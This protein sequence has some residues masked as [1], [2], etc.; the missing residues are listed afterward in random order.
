MTLRKTCPSWLLLPLEEPTPHCQL[1]FYN[2]KN[3]KGWQGLRRF[4]Q[5]KQEQ[6]KH[7]RIQILE[8]TLSFGQSLD[9]E[10]DLNMFENQCLMAVCFMAVFERQDLRNK[11]RA[12][13][14][15]PLKC[16]FEMMKTSLQAS[17]NRWM[18]WQNSNISVG[19]VCG[20]NLRFHLEERRFAAFQ[21]DPNLINTPFTP[22][23]R[24]RGLWSPT[25]ESR[26]SASVKVASASL[27]GWPRI[28]AGM[29]AHN[30]G[31]RDTSNR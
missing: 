25:S 16:E 14:K 2:P 9:F 24:H 3:E 19:F 18:R 4:L 23:K 13:N 28:A 10:V 29:L 31:K 8:K 5:T 6:F 26:S 1:H 7:A 15:L 20:D 22:A 21:G 12:A 30:S 17:S 27:R 11:R